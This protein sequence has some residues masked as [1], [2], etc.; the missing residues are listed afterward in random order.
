MKKITALALLMFVLFISVQKIGIELIQSGFGRAGFNFIITSHILKVIFLISLIIFMFKG[1]CCLVEHWG[2]RV[3]LGFW[4]IPLFFVSC[5][6][7]MFSGRIIHN[8]S[9]PTRP[10][11]FIKD[12]SSVQ[13][14]I[15]LA[16]EMI[17]KKNVFWVG[18]GLDRFIFSIRHGEEGYQFD[19]KLIPHNYD[20]NE[21]VKAEDMSKVHHLDLPFQ[22]GDLKPTDKIVLDPNDYAFC[23][24]A[25]KIIRKI[26]FDNV[27]LYP[28]QN[29]VQY[30]VCDLIGWDNGGY[31]VYY[32][33][34]NTTLPEKFK[35]EKKLNEHWYYIWESRFPK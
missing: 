10:D 23:K 33:C 31:Y 24:R 20:F 32:F 9:R 7:T 17:Q 2:F 5:T 26:G 11:L 6:A 29:V 15:D 13:K 30:Q 16:N 35:Y 14:L 27:K 1:V 3:I 19:S 22:S 25:S 8:L 4:C 28:E 21:P 18:N 12:Q 34:P